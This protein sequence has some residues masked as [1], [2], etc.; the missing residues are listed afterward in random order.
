MMKVTNLK[1]DFLLSS[2][3]FI[4]RLFSSSS[5]SAISV[6]SSVYLMLLI[7]LVA[8]LIPTSAIIC[9][10]KINFKKSISLLNLKL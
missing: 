6:V 1:P 9:Q 5:L 3:T 10:L 8:N 7:F 4:K 2:F